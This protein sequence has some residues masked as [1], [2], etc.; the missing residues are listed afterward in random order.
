VSTADEGRGVTAIARTSRE[1]FTI[2]RLRS[3]RTCP[4]YHDYKYNQRLEVVDDDG[5]AASFGTAGHAGLE[6]WLLA[7][8]SDLPQNEILTSALDTAEESARC[9]GFD[10]FEVERLRAV[11]EGYHYRWIDH[12]LEVLAVEAQFRAPMRDPETGEV[13]DVDE[14]GKMDGVVRRD[15]RLLILEHKFTEQD[16]SPGTPYWVRLR[17]DG[18]ISIYLDGAATL[19][20]HAEGCL[21]DVISKP[22]IIPLRATPLESRKYTQG[23]GCKLC[24]GKTLGV[25]GAGCAACLGGWVESPRLYANQRDTDETPTDFGARVRAA[26]AESPERYYQRAPIVR[27]AAEL[28][29]ARRDVWQTAAQIQQSKATGAH[30]RNDGACSHM[31]GR[32]CPFLAACCGEASIHD[33]SRYRRRDSAHPELS[34]TEAKEATP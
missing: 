34:I 16:V 21:Y 7:I 26:I 3:Y 15:G 20:F 23:K 4:R 11:L 12:P 9:H 2:S 27:F 22:G 14:G 30:P 10:D 1:L 29:E 5:G 19:G 13:S 6:A 28:E 31:Y 33:Q 25:Q 18:Q 8:Q 17:V 32:P 24:G